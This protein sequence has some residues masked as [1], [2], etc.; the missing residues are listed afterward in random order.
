MVS[1]WKF[2]AMMGLI[3]DYQTARLCFVSFDSP[4]LLGREGINL[5]KIHIAIPSQ[6]GKK[7]NAQRCLLLVAVQQVCKLSLAGCRQAVE[8]CLRTPERNNQL[9]NCFICDIPKEDCV[10]ALT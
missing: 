6:L 2:C 4:N 10:R 1:G 5:D 8:L 9:G 7:L 3:K